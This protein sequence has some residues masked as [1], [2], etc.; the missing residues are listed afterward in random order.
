VDEAIRTKEERMKAWQLVEK[1][2]CQQSWALDE[3]YIAVEEDSPSA[4]KWCSFGAIIAA[5][6]GDR[7]EVIDRFR[8]V[9]GGGN[10]LVW[11][12][13]PD[14][15]QAQVVAAMKAADV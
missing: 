4:C 2:W 5:Y 7:S 6:K 15:T 3:N 9:I 1:G 10:I 8:E 12:D 11:N 14:R 13:A